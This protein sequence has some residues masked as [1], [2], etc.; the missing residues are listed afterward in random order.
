MATRSWWAIAA[1]GFFTL[2]P[3][4]SAEDGT[5][6]SEDVGSG[7]PQGTYSFDGATG[8]Y[9]LQ[10]GGEI[11]T[12]ADAFHYVYKTLDGDGEIC[13]RI[14]SQDYVDSWSKAGVVIRQNTATGSVHASLMQTPGHG[15]TFIFRTHTDAPDQVNYMMTNGAP[16]WVK[17]VRSGTF[18]AGY[19]SPDGIAW[20]CQAIV[21]LPFNGPITA[22]LAVCSRQPM[23]ATA[24]FD[25]VTLTET[26]TSKLPDPWIDQEVGAS[27]I[28]GGSRYS[29]GIWSV[30]AS[31]KDIGDTSDGCHFI[32]QFLDGDGYITARFAGMLNI[33][34][35][36]KAGL[37]MRENKDPGAKQVSLL[38][39]PQNGALFVR[40]L[41]TNEAAAQDIYSL[42][43]PVWLRLV[44]E[45]DHIT[46]FKSA[47]GKS[48]QVLGNDQIFFDGPIEIGLALTSHQG[49]ALG[50]ASFDH[51][52]VG[53]GTPIDL[54]H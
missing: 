17:L 42:L 35:G 3:D 32:S 15:L 41:K 37:M 45:G 9:T 12:S 21:Q 43:G 22:G 24:T 50:E 7:I 44:R 18:M 20:T 5:W 49:D 34:V 2:I 53:K 51:V 47:D 39:T 54:A 48:W 40:R 6:T 11:W 27:G 33:D 25:H 46:A 10:G 28:Q 14:V 4:A 29:N 31:G 30:Y 38:L 19:Y 16:C 52:E 23:L 8:V 13:A 36:A 26:T 1:L